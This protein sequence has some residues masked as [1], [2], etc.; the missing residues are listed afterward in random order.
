MLKI[1]TNQRLVGVAFI[2]ISSAYLWFIQ[3]IPLDFW[4]ESEPF[5]ARTMPYLF[6]YAGLGTAVLLILA[7]SEFFDWQKL[8]GL[9]Y[10]RALY[11]LTL[12]AAYGWC[13]DYLGFITSSIAL[14]AGGF[15]ILGERR[16]IPILL[17]A[18]GL[19]LSFYFG[20]DLLGIY[21]SPGELWT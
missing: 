8:K 16:P 7:P 12:L 2:V 4:S 17:A 21:L 13:I 14:L 20:L 18:I 3:D 10:V 6:G 19:S 15:I 9:E 1:I 5:N 11:L